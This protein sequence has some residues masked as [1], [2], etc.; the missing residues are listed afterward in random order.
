M[1][2]ITNNV[3][4]FRADEPDVTD[5]LIR[6]VDPLPMEKTLDEQKKL[7]VYQ[8]HSLAN[9]LWDTLPGGTLDQL[10]VELL[11]RHASLLRVRFSE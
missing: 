8:A 2:R 1:K 3:T 7:Y 6:I 10:V 11:T 4:I 5:L 9:A